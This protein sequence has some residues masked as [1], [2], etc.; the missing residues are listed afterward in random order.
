M[1]SINLLK[2]ITGTAKPPFTAQS[3]KQRGAL[4]FFAVV[5]RRQR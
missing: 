4:P 2:L 5:L 3:R 1:N